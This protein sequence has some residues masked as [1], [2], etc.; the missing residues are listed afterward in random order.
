MKTLILG[1]TFSVSIDDA[2]SAAADRL[3]AW[4][5]SGHCPYAASRAGTHFQL[6]IPRPDRHRWSPWLTLDV[7]EPLGATSD[8]DSTGEVGAEA[9]GRFNPSPAIWTGY[10]LTSLALVTI[11]FG[12]AMWGVAELLVRSPPRALLVIP[13]C[14][15]VLV[16]MWLFSAAGQRLAR[17]EM[18]AMQSN[19]TRVLADAD[20]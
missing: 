13:V 14:L 11:A 8:A 20:E 10:M 18:A 2:P 1:P 6:A 16:A 5:D 9:F 4:I 17:D 3:S 19:I 15:V 7:R 12:A